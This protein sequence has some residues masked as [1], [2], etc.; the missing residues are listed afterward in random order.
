MRDVLDPRGYAVAAAFIVFMAMKAA[1]ASAG[2]TTAAFDI[3][4][5][6][7]LVWKVGAEAAAAYEWICKY[8]IKGRRLILCFTL[9]EYHLGE[10]RDGFSF[11]AVWLLTFSE[12]GCILRRKLS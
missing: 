10:E 3:G 8:R 6:C 4:T 12:Y 1:A 11:N 9:I 5:Y 7:L 2:S